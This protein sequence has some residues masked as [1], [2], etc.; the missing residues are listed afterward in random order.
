M[1]TVTTTRAIFAASNPMVTGILVSIPAILAMA[2][3][4][5]IL[6]TSKAWHVAILLAGPDNSVQGVTRVEGANQRLRPSPSGQ[7][8]ASGANV[9]SRRYN[10]ASIDPFA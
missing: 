9:T 2:F 1:P 10:R 4:F 7:S 6:V 5:D 3:A 8:Q